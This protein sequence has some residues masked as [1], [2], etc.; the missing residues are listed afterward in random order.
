MFS[1]LVAAGWKANTVGEG[2]VELTQGGASIF[3]SPSQGNSQGRQVVAMLEKQ[4]SAQ[5]RNFRQDSGGEIMLGGRRG[6]SATYTGINPKGQAT[7]INLA[8]L[9]ATPRG[10]S[11]YGIIITLPQQQLNQSRQ[12]LSQ[13]MPTL[14]FSR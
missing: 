12:A 7:W 1:M 13:M 3:I 9:D 2:A 8:G 14:K 4:F 11:A 6:W 10:G 5:T